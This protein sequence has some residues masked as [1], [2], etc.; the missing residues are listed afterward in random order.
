MKIDVVIGEDEFSEQIAKRIDAKF[1][2]IKTHVFPDSEVKPILETELGI[3]NSNILFVFRTNRFKPSIN[4]SLMKVF[5]VASLLKE[6]GANEINLLLPYMFYSRQDKQFLPGEVKSFSNIAALYENL[7]IS[8]IITVNSHLYG[9]EPA[10]QSFFRKIKIHDLSPA[11]IFAYYLRT[12]NLKNPIVIGPGKGADRLIQEL[13]DILDI[14]FED[15]EKEKDHRTLEVTMK[16]P[17]SNLK[18]RDVIIYDD[19]AAAG[20]TI[21]KAFEVVSDFKPNK[22]FIALPHIISKE[23]IE[24]ISNLKVSEIVTTDSFISEESSKFTELS[25]IPFISNYIERL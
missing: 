16:P 19:V 8:N 1:I 21:I 25:L 14:D 11:I 3:K 17:K 7:G 2:K 15:L 5:F 4:D 18:N 6:I 10:L 23:G 20:G 22:I 12:K 9:K 24:K 13:A